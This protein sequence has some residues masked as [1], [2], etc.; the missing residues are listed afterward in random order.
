MPRTTKAAKGGATVTPDHRSIEDAIRE[1]AYQLWEHDRR[2][3]GKDV[4]YWLRAESEVAS[5][6]TP[7]PKNAAAKPKT[8]A[9]SP[10]SRAKKGA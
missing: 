7:A 4:D 6:P 2:P 5:T 1:R 9:K 8:S 3:E 10:A